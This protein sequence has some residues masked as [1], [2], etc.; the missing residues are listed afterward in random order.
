MIR[1]GGSSPFKRF[2]GYF[3][4]INTKMSKS[5]EDLNIIQKLTVCPFF[6]R[7]FQIFEQKISQRKL[8]FNGLILNRKTNVDLC[9]ITEYET[10]NIFHGKIWAKICIGIQKCVEPLK[11][12]SLKLLWEQNQL[13]FK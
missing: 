11:F 12:V 2:R 13:R 6:L 7:T 1:C 4:D 8:I 10:K 9:V 3:L 5:T